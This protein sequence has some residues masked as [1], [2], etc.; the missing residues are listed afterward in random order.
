MTTL[1]W[2]RLAILRNPVTELLGMILD[3]IGTE[4]GH[5]DWIH[6]WTGF[7]RESARFEWAGEPAVIDVLNL[8]LPTIADP[9]CPDELYGIPG[10]RLVEKAENSAT[11]HWLPARIDLRLTRLASV[12]GPPTAIETRLTEARLAARRT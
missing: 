7:A 6:G 12:P 5:A 2:A 1:E 10:L 3:R 11:L 8:L 9:D 4:L